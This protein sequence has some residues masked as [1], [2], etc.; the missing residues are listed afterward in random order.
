MPDYFKKQWI[1]I[2]LFILILLSFVLSIILSLYHMLLGAICFLV[3]LIMAIFLIRKTYVYSKEL[4]VYIEEISERVK[5][6]SEGSFLKIPIG[7]ILYNEEYQLV[8][9]NPFMLSILGDGISVGSYLYDVHSSII[10][11]IKEEQ[12]NELVMIHNRVYRIESNKDE[13]L[14]YFLDATEETEMQDLYLRQ[15]TVFGVIFLDNYEDVTQNLDDHLRSNLNSLVTSLINQWSIQNGIYAKRTASDRFFIVL[16]QGILQQLEKERFS[17][18]DT[19]REET[20]Q[21]GLP[22]TLSIGIG[23]LAPRLPEL[24]H[25]AQSSLDLALSRGGDQVAV[26]KPN[27]KVRFFGGKT[28]PVEKRTRVR[29]R[30]IS[31]AL[32][33]LILESKRVIIMG[34]KFPDMDA[35][36]A[37]IGILKVVEANDREGFI[38]INE[39][40][41]DK[42]L[43][44]L[45]K[46][47]KKDE[48]LYSKIISSQEALQFID[49]DT[50]LIVVDTHLSSMVIEEQLLIKTEK[51]IVI[52]HHRRGEDFIKSPVLVYMEPYASSTAELVTELLEYQPKRLKLSTLE[53]TALLAGIIVDTKSFTLRTGSRT[54]DA[55]GYLRQRGADTVLVQK[56][57]KE[58]F[59]TYLKKS[60]LVETAHINE[61]GVAIAKGDEST[62]YENILIAQ[63]ADTLLS[64]A[65][66]VAS[67]VI[68]KRQDGITGISAR[69]LGDV[70]VQLI[71][72]KMNG[73]GHLTNAATQLREHTVVEAEQ[74][75][76]KQIYSYFE[77]EK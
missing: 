20:A 54:F 60:R 40:E 28:N 2:P 76:I 44:R 23:E 22:L 41:V 8:W 39:H 13:K 70:N 30:V 4:Q 55:A 53:A 35:I 43:E 61:Y 59:E 18:L 17:I 62:L 1:Q 25:L 51:I 64:M 73:G 71:M 26:K 56:L 5:E 36:G 19:V 21:K 9:M 34:H 74:M 46:E 31:H 67:F 58:D 52:D 33:D 24:G 49:G 3:S 16:N 63:A 42:S 7:I 11:L 14:L 10:P 50:L 72:E 57:L 68:A 47:V 66:V 29:A 65:N 77:E 12:T 75:L 37:S 15:Q 27:G 45:L 32:K 69:S 6:V 48:E 38:I